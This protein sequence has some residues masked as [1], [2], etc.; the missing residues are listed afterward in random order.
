MNKGL[1][2]GVNGFGRIGRYFTRLALLSDDI[3]VAVVN[4]VSDIQTLMHLLKY[5]SIHRG[6]S[7]QF[8]IEGN[9]A[10]FENGK[11]I[12][13]CQE[14]NPANIPW[15]KYGVDTVIESTG[16]FL[17]KDLASGH[18]IGG[19]KRVIISAPAIGDDIQTIVLGVNEDSVDFSESIISNA[20]CTT[21]NAAPMLKVMREL[22][23]IESAY[24]TTVHSYTTDQRLHDAPHRDLRRARAAATS[25]VP[26]TTGAAKA[27]TRIFPDLEG[28][29]GGCGV[30]VPVPDGSFTDLTMVVKNPPSVETI[31]AAMKRAAETSLKGILAYTE[32]PIV[33]V[34]VIGNPNSC[35]FDAQLTSVVH[36]MVKVVGWYDNEAGYSNR[37]IDLVRKV[38][39][40]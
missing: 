14:S 3:Q 34:D 11:R 17:R 9:T 6:F 31:N 38:S 7:L 27:L 20:S 32:D 23:E 33:S 10:I 39:K 12:V 24:I 8:K 25:I 29:I 2:T 5:D 22:C 13:F 1:T 36:S 15:A 16:H 35:L 37:L 21:N 26:T 40:S 28:C 18:L 19:A 4:D 30:R